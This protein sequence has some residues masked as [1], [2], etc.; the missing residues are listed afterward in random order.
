MVV[1]FLLV[2]VVL[3]VD[4]VL[5]FSVVAV[6]VVV[7]VAAVVDAAV[8]V[9]TEEVFCDADADESVPETFPIKLSVMLDAEKSAIAEERFERCPP[10]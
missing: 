6:V 1:V 3:V 8:V 9:V 2:V 4:V 7:V 5:D 10:A